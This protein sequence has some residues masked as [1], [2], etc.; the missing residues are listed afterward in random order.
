MTTINFSLRALAPILFALL[1][2]GCGGDKKTPPVGTICMRNSE[3]NNPLSCSFGRCHETCVET[4]D[5]PV[6]QRCLKLAAGSVCQ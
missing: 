4:R 3:C 6:G 1:I 5:C 2:S